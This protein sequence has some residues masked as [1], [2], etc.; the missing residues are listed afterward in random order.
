FASA[1]SEE[2]HSTSFFCAAAA[3]AAV[4]SRRG[5]NAYK[6][7]S[8]PFNPTPFYLCPACELGFCREQAL[9]TRGRREI[10]RNYQLRR[11]CRIDREQ[12]AGRREIRRNY[13][14]RRF[15]RIDSK[16]PSTRRP[17]RGTIRA[18]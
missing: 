18:S 13:Q 15:C 9:E 7:K 10:R 6:A 8:Y 4:K 11:F 1:R 5:S 12:G 14:L 16:Q 2:S 17:T 3:A